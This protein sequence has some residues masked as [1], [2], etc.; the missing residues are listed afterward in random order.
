[1]IAPTDFRTAPGWHPAPAPFEVPGWQVEWFWHRRTGL[2]GAAALATEMRSRPAGRPP[3]RPNITCTFSDQLVRDE[4]GPKLV[5]DALEGIVQHLA[6]HLPG[7][8]RERH[9]EVDRIVFEE[10][11]LELHARQLP[12]KIAIPRALLVQ[13]GFLRFISGGVLEQRGNTFAVRAGRFA[14]YR[15]IDHD[16]RDVIAVK[17]LEIWP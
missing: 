9:P 13:R 3:A 11:G 15:A 4:R 7:A 14:R 6:A 12:R 17:E 1:M 5:L 10:R 16:S 2:W 8:A